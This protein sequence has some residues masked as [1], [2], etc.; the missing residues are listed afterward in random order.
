MSCLNTRHP[1][2]SIAKDNGSAGVFRHRSGE[3]EVALAR[4]MRQLR[5]KLN[6]AVPNRWAVLLVGLLIGYGFF[7]Q[8]FEI[9]RASAPL[10]IGIVVWLVLWLGLAILLI[11]E[12]ANGVV[13]HRRRKR[14]ENQR[15]A[16]LCG[17]CGYDL[18]AAS[19]VR[20]PE[21]GAW[22]GTSMATRRGDPGRRDFQG[23]HADLR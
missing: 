9:A 1:G 11:M 5:Q 12:G 7:S 18:R 21:C 10:T 2:R 4:R 6:T 20:C 23:P 22:S 19:S 3:S 16:G 13:S 17:R 8:I 15:A 14:Y